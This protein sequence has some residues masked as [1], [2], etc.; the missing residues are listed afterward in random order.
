ME[1][2]FWRSFLMRWIAKRDFL[3]LE[4][5]CA[6]FAAVAISSALFAAE[7]SFWFAGLIAGAAYALVYIRSGNLW[8][9]IIAHA[10]TNGILGTWILLTGNWRYW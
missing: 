1:E 4:P 10:T 5:K 9:P 3:A 7:H 2:L 8:T 6:G